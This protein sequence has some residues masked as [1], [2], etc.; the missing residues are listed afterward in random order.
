MVETSETE[1]PVRGSV[2][3]RTIQDLIK[4]DELCTVE[5]HPGNV[6]DDEDS[7]NADQHGGQVQLSTD[8]PVSRLLMGVPTSIVIGNSGS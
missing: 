7:H 4:H 2:G 5:D 8:C 6:T 1:V 3:I